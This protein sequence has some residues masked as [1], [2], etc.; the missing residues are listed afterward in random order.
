MARAAASTAR[1]P[2]PKALSL[3]ARWTRRGASGSGKEVDPEWNNRDSLEK[4]TIRDS[5]MPPEEAGAVPALRQAASA[6]ARAGGCKTCLPRS[7]CPSSSCA[8]D[9]LVVEHQETGSL[10]VAVAHRTGRGGAGAAHAE[11][12]GAGGLAGALVKVQGFDRFGEE[13][14]CR[15]ELLDGRTVSAVLHEGA[16]EL[17]VP[18][19][20]RWL[21]PGRGRHG[22]R[23]PRRERAGRP[24]GDRWCQ[25]E[26]AAGRGRRH[27]PALRRLQPRCQPRGRR[28][29]TSTWNEAAL[30]RSA[31]SRSRSAR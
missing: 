30:S 24:R 5:M 3:L 19:G 27:L 13:V 4:R 23:G 20:G 11:K 2:G 22:H 1:G 12:C 28:T 14:L 8:P 26:R 17:R 21:H 10:A 18:A 29:R 7:S 31:T 9:M 25:T 16:A 15:V 6:D